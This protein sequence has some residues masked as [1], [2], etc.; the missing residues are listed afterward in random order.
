MNMS[1]A[2]ERLA[3]V[4]ALRGF[5][6][7]MIAGLGSFFVLLGGKT[8]WPWLQTVAAQF[9]HPAWDGFTF[10]DFIF[11]LFLFM[12]G[13]SLAFSLNSTRNQDLPHSVLFKKAFK[14]MLILIGVGIL[15][16]NAPLPVFDPGQ[17]RLGSVLGRIG[18]AGFITTI[19][20]LNF[21]SRGRMA[22]IA[23]ILLV[24]YAALYLIPVPGYGAGDLSFEGNV[25]GWFDRQFLP[26]RLLQKSFDE[27]GLLTQFPALC[28]TMLGAFAGDI[29]RGGESGGQKLKTLG[30]IGA[31]GIVLGLLWALHFP[32]NKHLWTSSFILLT[33]GMAYLFL[34]LFYGLIDVCGF[35][36]WAFSFQVIGL[37]S[38][39]IYLLNGF[40]DFKHTFGRLFAGI[41]R[42]APEPWHEVW[43]AL[44]ALA[45][46]WLVLYF[47]YRNKLFL[48]V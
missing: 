41:Y 22:W 46:V 42:H 24:Y 19:L 18:F 31:G 45:L 48:K 6:M 3:S 5:D 29:L 25:V 39:T 15:Y 9:K 13:V 8:D 37:N 1:N 16:K 35:K 36:K 27:L 14:R 38:L 10:Y 34:A 7:L 17:I 30:L 26:G 43:Q 40:I 33:G 28:L 44:G 4:D 2:S 12:A 23:A 47:L 20:Y 32:I 21:S 11:P